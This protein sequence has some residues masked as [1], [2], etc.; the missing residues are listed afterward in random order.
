MKKY[1]IIV[2][3]CDNMASAWMAYT[4]TRSDVEFVTLVDPV[5]VTKKE[6]RKECFFNEVRTF[7]E[8]ATYRCH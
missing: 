7:A 6:S 5:I 4:P 8:A 3:G 1:C 2:V